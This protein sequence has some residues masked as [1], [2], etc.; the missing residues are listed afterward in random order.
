MR[1]AAPHAMLL[2]APARVTAY[3]GVRRRR[4]ALRCAAT[5]QRAVRRLQ[6]VPM[7]WTE[8]SD[9]HLSTHVVEGYPKLTREGKCVVQECLLRSIIFLGAVRFVQN[10]VLLVDILIANGGAGTCSTHRGRW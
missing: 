5:Q 8:A 7:V 1:A 10:D 9:D 4:G 2:R 6:L 3:F